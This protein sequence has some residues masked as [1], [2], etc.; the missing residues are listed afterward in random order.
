MKDFSDN[1]NPTASLFSGS[2]LVFDVM[3]FDTIS[4]SMKRIALPL[5]GHVYDVVIR[6]E[7]LGGLNNS[8]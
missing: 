4:V 7:Y 1:P 3:E 8:N 5:S 2:F 6:S